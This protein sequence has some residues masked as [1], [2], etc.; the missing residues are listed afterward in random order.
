MEKL[1]EMILLRMKSEGLVNEDDIDIYQFGLECLFLK[2]IH[3]LSYL[4]ISYILRMMIPMLVSAIVF[5]PLRS[6]SGGYHAKTRH[7]CYLFSCAVVSLICILN[8]VMY[9]VWTFALVIFVSNI[10]VCAFAPVEHNNR[11]LEL[12]ERKK[13]REQELLL[14]GLADMLIIVTAVIGVNASRWLL[15]GMLAA[16]VLI[17]LG[18]RESIVVVILN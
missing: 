2:I 8:K 18:C 9:S 1:I 3:Y 11:T 13:L 10:V 7:G 14:L 5:M 17:L 12:S 16:V 4:F 6:K 15:N